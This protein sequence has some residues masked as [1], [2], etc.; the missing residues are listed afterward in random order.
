MYTDR[1]AGGNEIEYLSSIELTT[2]MSILPILD[3]PSGR[4]EGEF[5]REEGIHVLSPGCSL[6]ILHNFFQDPKKREKYLRRS[7]K[8]ERIQGSSM[9]G[10]Q[11]EPRR[12]IVYSP[13]G[14]DWHYSGSIHS[15][16]KYPDY[17]LRIV[18][19]I[20]KIIA[21]NFSDEHCSELSFSS[22]IVYD[23]AYD[24]GGSI[25]AHSDSGEPWNNIAVLNHGQTRWFRVRHK[26]SKKFYNIEARDDSLILMHGKTFQQ[27][28]THQV[29]KLP[30]SVEIG[31]RI[32]LN[33][34]WH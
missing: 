33:I 14:E 2:D 7:L 4:I 9:G 20:E 29:D 23:Q 8:E 11:K 19:Y 13:N 1:N 26:K 25:G 28:Y 27:E 6:L 24:R 12:K 16:I 15:S 31:T 10:R 21:L 18:R 22:S 30:K 5:F 3:C 34:R 17:V 32:S